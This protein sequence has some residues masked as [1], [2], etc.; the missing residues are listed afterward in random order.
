MKRYEKGH[1]EATVRIDFYLQYKK[2]VMQITHAEDTY[3]VTAV[4]LHWLEL[5]KQVP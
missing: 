3:V 5:E 2:H 1:I 4:L